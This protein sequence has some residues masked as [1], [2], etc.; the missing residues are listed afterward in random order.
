MD[1]T[2]TTQQVRSF[3]RTVTQRIGVL[4]DEYLARGRQLGASRVLWEIG[5]AAT[6]LRSLR[7]RLDLD[8]GYLSRLVRSLQRDGLIEVEPDPTDKRVR[9]VRLTAAG[10]A[11]RDVLDQRSDELALSLLAPL[12]DP[13][14][15]RLV[16]AMRTVERLLTA[17]LVEVAI[18]DPTSP[19][20][21]FC[22]GSY[23]KELDARFDT[24]FDPSH[25]SFLGADEMTPPVGLLLVARLHGEPVGC[26]ALR[27]PRPATAEIKRMW[28]APT[29]RGLGLGRRLLGEL[30]QHARRH[31]ARV[32]RL[33][34]NK[35]LREAISL[36][37][38][39]GY[40]E[41]EPFNDDPYPDHWFEKRLDA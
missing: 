24:G 39:A 36:Y 12:S 2:A 10:R 17:G 25:G 40:T 16:E 26:G 9:A 34:T 37:H 3:N 21:R 7:A 38:S 6:D 20:A 31:G 22:L 27:F 19:D 29:A 32:V 23:F 18:E 35:A 11:E 4:Y 30:E 15:A 8:S 13:Q 1:A 5:D 33:D 28:V 41:V 14:R